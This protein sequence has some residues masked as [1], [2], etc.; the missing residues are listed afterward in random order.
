MGSSG[1][2]GST[3]TTT[4]QKLSPQSKELLN[5]VMPTIKGYVNPDGTVNA[6]TYPGSTVAPVNANQTLGQQMV[7]GQTG[8]AQGEAASAGQGIN[9]LTSGQVLDPNSNPYLISAINAAIRPITENY[10][11]T[12]LGNIRDNAQLAGAF[13]YNRQGLEDSAAAE[14]YMKQVGD[15]SASMANTN[16]Q[17]GLDAMSR[18]MA[19]APSIQQMLYTPGSA[20]AGV[21]QQQQE[22]A[23]QQLDAEVQ[24]FYQQQY[25][26]LSL[27]EEIAGIAY[28]NPAGSASTTSTG[29]G[30]NKLQ[31][32]LGLGAAGASLGSMIMPGAGTAAGGALGALL[33]LFG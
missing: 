6:S 27:A 14:N 21:G 22:L 16:Y 5:L 8:A 4:Q 20:V 1:G 30:T 26:P 33:G 11:Q 17:A 31:S 7:L 9:F 32:A 15:T 10:T 23:Q 25:L 3:T 19:F 24:Q 18:S 28:G 13:G 29:G 2:S 12:V